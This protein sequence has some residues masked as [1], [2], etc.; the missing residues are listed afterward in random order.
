ME[1][2]VKLDIVPAIGIADGEVEIAVQAAHL[3]D[4]R[5]TVTGFMDP[6]ATKP[7]MLIFD[8]LKASIGKGPAAD[9]SDCTFHASTEDFIAAMKAQ[10]DEAGD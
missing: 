4:R 10:R 6:V 8:D 3:H 9:L 5:V 7:E 1:P 2:V